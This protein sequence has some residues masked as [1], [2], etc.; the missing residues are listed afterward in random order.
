MTANKDPPARPQALEFLR[1]GRNVPGRQPYLVQ[2]LGHA[3][4]AYR[5]VLA[6]ILG[7]LAAVAD[8]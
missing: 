7:W 2:N 3:L 6:P 5:A 4:D 8:A 1:G